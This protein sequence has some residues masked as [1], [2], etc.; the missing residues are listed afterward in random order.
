[1]CSRST[2]LRLS[3]NIRAWEKWSSND[4]GRTRSFTDAGT[5]A[6]WSIKACS[7]SGV[8]NGLPPSSELGRYGATP[9][10]TALWW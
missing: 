3:Q 10:C 2:S 4:C 8:S 5:G 7:L 9:E 6:G 1:M